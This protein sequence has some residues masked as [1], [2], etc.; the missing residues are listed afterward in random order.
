M[1]S[2]CTKVRK[3]K[4]TYNT[5]SALNNFCALIVNNFTPHIALAIKHLLHSHKGYQ[6]N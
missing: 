4:V 5:Q 1:L 6:H 3:R 2:I